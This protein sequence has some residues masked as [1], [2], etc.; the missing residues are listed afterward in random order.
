MTLDSATDLI[1]QTLILALIVSA[2]ML[3]DRAGRRRPRLASAGGHADP[4]ADAHLR[5]EIVAM[6]VAAMLLMPW[7]GHRL[8]E[9]TAA[10]LGP[11]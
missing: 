3:A 7:I 9:Y 8:L 5:A 11:M 4:G 1:R 2:P 10:M 6:V